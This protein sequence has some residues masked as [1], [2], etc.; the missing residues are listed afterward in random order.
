[1]DEAQGRE[2]FGTPGEPVPQVDPEDIKAAWELG[3]EVKKDHP[4]G[5]VGI[6][7]EIFKARCKPGADIPAVTYR[8][9][10]IAMLQHAGP[11]IMTP[12]IQDKLDAVFLAAA[13]IPMEWMGVGI[14]RRGLPFDA[15]DFI[16]RVSEAA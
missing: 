15:D 14:T 3:Q 2:F 6:G 7:V 16:R 5:N 1:M 13:Q 12:L 10:M 9:N 8:A 11:E 4:K